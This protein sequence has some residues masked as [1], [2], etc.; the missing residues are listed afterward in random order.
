MLMG[1]A[2]EAGQQATT[3]HPS[4]PSG[5][6]YCDI[7]LPVEPTVLRYYFVLRDGTTVRQRHQIEGEVEMLYGVWEER[8]FQIAG[9]EMAN[10]RDIS[11]EAGFKLNVC[12]ID[13]DEQQDFGCVGRNSTQ[14][15]FLIRLKAM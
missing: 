15:K 9:A 7:L 6:W 1:K 4:L 2:A 13:F 5:H 10:T 11:G 14:T 12:R 3:D 8:D